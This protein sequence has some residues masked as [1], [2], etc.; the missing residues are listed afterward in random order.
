MHAELIIFL[1]YEIFASLLGHWI[2]D[3]TI[4]FDQSEWSENVWWCSHV[5]INPSKLTGILVLRVGLGRKPSQAGLVPRVCVCLLISI[6]GAHPGQ[7]G[8]LIPAGASW[9][10]MWRLVITPLPSQCQHKSQSR[11]SQPADT[12][13]IFSRLCDDQTMG[14]DQG[15]ASG[16]LYRQHV[17]LSR[18]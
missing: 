16:I 11:P 15:A 18:N 13:H 3:E 7:P 9:P 6:C 4:S 12:P 5:T 10:D 2:F 17:M 8:Q 14:G 1:D